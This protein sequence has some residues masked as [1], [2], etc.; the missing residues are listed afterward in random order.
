LI[1]QMANGK[2]QMAFAICQ[3]LPFQKILLFCIFANIKRDYG[4]SAS[5]LYLI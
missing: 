4:I 1:W 5:G 2:W 3:I